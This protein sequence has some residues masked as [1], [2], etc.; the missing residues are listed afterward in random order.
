MLAAAVP[1]LINADS[2]MDFV[3]AGLLGLGGGLFAATYPCLTIEKI[4]ELRLRQYTS[5]VAAFVDARDRRS[6]EAGRAVPVIV[7][8]VDDLAV[9]EAYEEKTSCISGHATGGRGPVT[10]ALSAR[11]QRTEAIAKQVKKGSTA[12]GNA[13]RRIN[14]GLAALDKDLHASDLKKSERRA[15]LQSGGTEINQGLNALD[16][17]I[18]T[19]LIAAYADELQ[20]PVTIPTKHDASEA[21]S[22]LLASYG[23]SLNTVLKSVEGREQKRPAFPVPTGVTDAFAYIGHFLPIAAIVAVVELVFP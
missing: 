19:A 4:D 23:D 11:R 8:F 20:R 17:A 6:S 3:K 5:D 2:L 1:P 15:A 12:E 13:L 16:E 7:S 22:N 21:V 14:G 18:P 9:K 10:R